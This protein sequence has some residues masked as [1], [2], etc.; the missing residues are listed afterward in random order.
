MLATLL[1]NH[2][3]TMCNNSAGTSIAP[4]MALCIPDFAL[5][6]HKI[7]THSGFIIVN[8]C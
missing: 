2:L 8:L 6:A 3:S 7:E 4:L 1:C 5:K